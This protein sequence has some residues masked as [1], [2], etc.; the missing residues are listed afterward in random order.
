MRGIQ[1]VGKQSERGVMMAGQKKAYYKRI[2]QLFGSS[3]IGYWPLTEGSGTVA[4]D[5]SSNARNGAFGGN[6]ALTN[7]NSK[8]GKRYPSFTA[9][10]VNINNTDLHTLIDN[11]EYTI[12][13]WV[14]SAN[15]ANAATEYIFSMVKDGSNGTT[16]SKR[17]A[18]IDFVRQ[19]SGVNKTGFCPTLDY[20]APVLLMISVSKAGD[21]VRAYLNGLQLYADATGLAATNGASWSSTYSVI[22]ALNTSAASPFIGSCGDVFIINRPVTSA[23]ANSAYRLIGGVKKIS[24]IGDSISVFGAGNWSTTVFGRYNNGS[25]QFASHAVAGQCIITTGGHTADMDAQV[26]A[27][28]NDNADKIIILLGT[29]DTVTDDTLRAEYEENLL[30]LKASNQSAIIHG[31]GILDRTD[32]TG[33]ADKR[34]RIQ[35]ACANTGAVYHDP[36]GVINTS[37]MLT[38]GTHLNALGN[39]ALAAWVLSWI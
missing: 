33:V 14:N 28:A 17:A 12:G 6:Y 16:I 22:G 1:T 19:A 20:I 34:T 3:L 27:S 31:V 10:Y 11:S 38:D 8:T 2:R 21:F 37:T 26:A 24:V 5:M 23:E 18:G 35:T 30:E 32:M 39:S 15:W 13:I 7:A 25:T 36:S 9:G 29:N 4:R